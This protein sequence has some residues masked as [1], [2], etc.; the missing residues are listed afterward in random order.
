MILIGPFQLWKLYDLMTAWFYDLHWLQPG[1]TRI[2]TA[3]CRGNLG[4]EDLVPCGSGTRRA[5][6]K[7]TPCRWNTKILFSLAETWLNAKKFATLPWLRNSL[8]HLGPI[9][10][11]PLL[12]CSKPLIHLNI[13]VGK[14]PPLASHNCSARSCKHSSTASQHLLHTPGKC[15][16]PKTWG[17]RCKNTWDAP[18]AFAYNLQPHWA[19]PVFAANLKDAPL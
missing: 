2:A 18:G 15:K 11:L 17:K 16:T 13:W 1:K 8:P 5:M 12:Q 9:P 10:F 19:V 4:L 7:W 3:P 14:Q 6:W